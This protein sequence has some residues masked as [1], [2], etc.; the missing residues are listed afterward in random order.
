MSG[1]HPRNETVRRALQVAGITA[2]ITVLDV[3]ARTAA[4]AA[5]QLGCE[6]AAIA[7]S[8]V[9]V[10]DGQPLLVMASGAA[11]V[12]TDIIAEAVGATSVT[13]A[14]PEQVRAATGQVIGGVAPVGHPAPLRTLLDP[15][16]EDHETIWAAGGTADT[17][18]PL[19]FRQLTALTAGQVAPVR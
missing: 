1:M 19:S 5:E 17:I 10:A 15:D 16:L 2:E 12:D 6:V 13:M 8:L 4:L 11:R 18:M 9:L 3:H 7:N 14:R